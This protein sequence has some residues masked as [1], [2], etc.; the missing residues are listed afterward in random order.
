MRV[1][2]AF[3]EML[4]ITGASVASVSSTPAGIV[5]A[6]RRRRAKPACPCGFKTWSVRDRSTR[7]WRH[8]DLAGS[9]CWL[10]AEIRRLECRRCRRWCTE[11]VSWARPGARHSADIQDVVA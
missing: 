2:T 7:R 3:N 8:L 1:N 6:L 9:K 11:K 4:R 10:E 5:V